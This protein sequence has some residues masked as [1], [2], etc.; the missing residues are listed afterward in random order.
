MNCGIILIIKR[1]RCIYTPHFALRAK[2]KEKFP[3]ILLRGRGD[4]IPQPH[5]NRQIAFFIKYDTFP[6]TIVQDKM[7]VQICKIFHPV[8]RYPQPVHGAFCLQMQ[9]VCFRTQWHHPKILELSA[10][11]NKLNKVTNKIKVQVICPCSKASIVL[12]DVG[13]L[14]GFKPR[15]FN[16]PD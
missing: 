5:F 15:E 13:T 6:R 16:K 3:W 12:T 2:Q 7:P 10:Q 8:P 4:V 1:K 9:P 11:I 14:R